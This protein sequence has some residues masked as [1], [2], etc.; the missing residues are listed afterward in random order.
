VH[1]APH[2]THD[3]LLSSHNPRHSREKHQQGTDQYAFQIVHVAFQLLFT[4]VLSCAYSRWKHTTELS[5]IYITS[6]VFLI[7]RPNYHSILHRRGL[8]DHAT[9]PTV[10]RR[11]FYVF[12]SIVSS[13]VVKSVAQHA[14]QEVELSS[15]WNAGFQLQQPET[16]AALECEATSQLVEPQTESYQ[17]EFIMRP[18]S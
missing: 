12:T 7:I 14:H 4:L 10:V 2:Q 5:K 1:N 9:W 16:S 3:G 11:W 8:Q 13:P 6:T 18:S 15:E 17:I